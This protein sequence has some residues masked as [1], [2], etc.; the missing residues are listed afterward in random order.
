[1]RISPNTV[2]PRSW[3]ALTAVHALALQVLFSGV[4]IGQLAGASIASD[5]VAVI[6]AA[7]SESAD[8]D[9]TGSGQPVSAHDP[10]CVFCTA[11]GSPAVLPHSAA[12]VNI[13]FFMESGP[14]AHARDMVVAF[15]SPTGHYQ[16][17]PPD[18]AAIA[19]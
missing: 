18:S 8:A 7:H 12:I 13:P 11:T 2:R 10:I 4:L 6:C 3:V 5:G 15:A 16:R 19:G 17:G 14:A 9:G 1:M